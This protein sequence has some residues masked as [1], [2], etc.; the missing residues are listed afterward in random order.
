MRKLQ[1]LAI[2]EKAKA[3]V[4]AWLK[5]WIEHF[6]I[7][8]DGRTGNVYRADFEKTD[9]CTYPETYDDTMNEIKEELLRLGLL[10]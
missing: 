3:E 5:E 4:A 1:D 10:K 8:A 6:T 2:D 9:V 7:M